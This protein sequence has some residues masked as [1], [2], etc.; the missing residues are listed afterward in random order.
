M[1]FCLIMRSEIGGDLG[2]FVNALLLQNIHK[3]DLKQNLCNRLVCFV[4]LTMG[5]GWATTCKSGPHI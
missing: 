3:L 1:L 2:C 4:I 5:P